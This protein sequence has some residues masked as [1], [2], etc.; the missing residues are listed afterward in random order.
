MP[1][2]TKTRLMPYYSAEK[3][4]ELHRCFLKDMAREM[5][6]TD[7]DIIVAYTGG[8]PVYLRDT[9]GK[10][11]NFILQRGNDLGQKM[12]NA[13]ADVFSMGYDRVI[14]TGTDIP[15]LKA[16][17]VNT[18]FD[19]LDRFDVVLGPTSDGGYYLIGMK[20]LHHEAFNV[21]L[22][23]VST[24]FEE[25]LGSIR[26]SG[27]SA[28]AADEYSDIDDK[29]DIASLRNRIRK[30]PTAIGADTRRFLRNNLSV[31]VVVPVFNE[32]KTITRMMDQ[33]R[34]YKDEAEI[35]FVDGHSTDGTRSVIGDEFKVVMCEKGRGK[36]LNAGA[37]A[38]GGDILFFLH[39]D[40]VLPKRFLDEI[41]RC[42]MKKPFGC[43]GVRFD[44]HNFFMLT[45]RIISNYRALIRGIAFGDQGMFIERKLFF[46][47]GMFPEIPVMEDYEFS[48]KMKRKGYRPVMARRRL[49]TS[50]RR[51][52]RNTLSI[53]KTE[54]L[55][56]HLR[57]LYRRGED[58]GKIKTLYK[59]IREQDCRGS[60]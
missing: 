47:A 44:S 37:L 33:L 19:M 50:S 2:A 58:P 49:R 59:D 34:P 43:F 57:A 31:S 51:Y 27:L 32:S 45:N 28:G 40:S 24:V 55:M 26:R 5:K 53:I 52:G 4:A 22:Y 14:L 18:A 35:I 6:K 10:K 48:L 36:Q 23:G 20:K 60:L 46:E 12:E 29:D 9:F 38:S 42:V 25:T 11:A 16:D 54:M 39:C 21:K 13:F 1:G 7:A 56:W 15:E 41:R 17:S 8:E 30:D 3:C